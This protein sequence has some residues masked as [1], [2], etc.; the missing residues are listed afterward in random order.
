MRVPGSGGSAGRF[1]GGFGGGMPRVGPGLPLPPVVKQLLIANGAI[2]LLTRLIP[3]VD[4]VQLEDLFGFVPAYVFGQGRIWQFATYMFLHGDFIHILFNMLLIWMFGSTLE[5]RWG[6]RAFLTYYVVCGVGGAVLTWVL[7]PQSTSHV[8]GASAAAL[9]VLLAYTL[10]YPD[11]KVLLWFIVPVK[12]KYLLWA[13][14]SIDLIGAIGLLPGNIAHSAH[15]GG[16]LFGWIYLKQDW[17][18]GAIGRRY[19]ATR[20]RQ[21]LKQRAK[22]AERV[23]TRQ[24]EIDRILEKI[25]AEGMD[26][27]TDRELKILRDASRH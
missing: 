20:A 16:V 27:L 12:M 25:S 13:L 26:S 21:Q 10:M 15:L 19:R 11:Q 7:G 3:G 24:E 22:N 5:H 4:L 8:I 18:L 14:V 1:G 9:G 23:Q 6:S 17:R 2:F